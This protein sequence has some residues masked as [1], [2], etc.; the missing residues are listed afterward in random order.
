MHSLE[1]T[2][3]RKKNVQDDN[4]FFFVVINSEIWM[5]NLPWAY[6]YAYDGDGGDDVSV[7]RLR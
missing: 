7:F 6:A 1:H 4:I 3:T 2:Q 5:K